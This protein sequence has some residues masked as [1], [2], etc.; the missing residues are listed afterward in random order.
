MV[1]EAEDEADAD[2]AG[3]RQHVVV[4][5]QRVLVEDSHRVLDGYRADVVGAVVEAEDAHHLQPKPIIRC[6][7]DIRALCETSAF[8][9]TF[10]SFVLDALRLKNVYSKALKSQ[11]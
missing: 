7:V 10:N 6:G 3:S 2:G 5:L 11:S 9:E 1:V 8:A 4:V